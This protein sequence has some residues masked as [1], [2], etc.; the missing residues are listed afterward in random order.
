MT[1][2]LPT[3]PTPERR[4]LWRSRLYRWDSKG[5][6]YAFV[7]PFFVV[8]A[9]FGLFPL[10]YTGWLS[11]HQVSLYHVNQARWV[12]LGN[13]R[14]LFTGAPSRFFWNAL[15]NTVTLGA[16]STVPQLAM[17]IGLA[18]L[19]NY[20]LRAR[21]FLRT[22]LLAP[23]ATS[24]AAATLAF[25]LIFSPEGGMANWF[26]HLFGFGRVDWEA[27]RWSSQF[28]IATIV[29]WRW[30]G[31]N[32]LIYL[33]AMQAVPGELYEA[34]AIDGASRLRQFW[35][36]TVP[37]LRPTILFTV[38]I[39]TIGATQLFGEPF[40]FGGQSGHQGGA[41]NQYETLG[42]LMYDQG[43][44]NSML[45]RASAVAWTMFA[46]LLLLGLVNALIARR[47]RRS[48]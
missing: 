43:F 20:R 18:H 29:T 30:T 27:G 32:A 15:R 25:A 36:V 23:Y 21:G 28:A 39:S 3:P 31:Y 44:H 24:V 48:Q 11:L 42:V 38:V 17:A 45:G 34:A 12:G 7:A 1:R 2:A 8:F 41:D 35:H 40:L 10:L 46:L 37:A 47:L 14:D 9:A 26:I 5:T 6:P 22:A 16:L 4:Q 13:Y 19:L 33:A